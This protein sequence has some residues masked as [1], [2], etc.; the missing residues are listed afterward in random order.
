MEACDILNKRLAPVRT[1]MRQ[2]KRAEPTWQELITKAYGAG[3][4]LRSHAW[5][6]ASTPNAFAYNS[7]A[8]ACSEGTAHRARCSLPS[9][10]WLTM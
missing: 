10:F 4:E 6:T 2:D 3:I 7:Y 1:M 5:I 9:T 8:V